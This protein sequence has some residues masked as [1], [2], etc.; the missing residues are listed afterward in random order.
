ML[1]EEVLLAAFEGDPASPKWLD[2]DTAERLAGAV[3][4]ASVLPGQAQQW[5]KDVLGASEGW[6]PKLGELAGQRAEELLAAHRRVRAAANLRGVRYR[7]QPHREV[8][9]LGVYVLMPDRRT[10]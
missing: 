7:V 9:L 6:M 5:L 1:A 2:Q 3:P 4:S 8:D 10:Q